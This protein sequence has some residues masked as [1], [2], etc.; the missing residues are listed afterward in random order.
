MKS[1][2]VSY[3]V[4]L[5]VTYETC[6]SLKAKQITT[7]TPDSG[8]YA[9]MVFQTK[10]AKCT[11]SDNKGHQND[12]CNHDM[13]CDSKLRCL[14]YMV[15]DGAGRKTMLQHNCGDSSLC[16]T[17]VT[18]PDT[19]AQAQIECGALKNGLTYAVAMIAAYL[20]I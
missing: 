7:Y 11:Y 19:D 10:D 20:A 4:D 12:V 16:A 9:N 2:Q 17:N 8:P 13:Q 14:K 6:A 18:M 3:D 5:C 1:G 15:Y